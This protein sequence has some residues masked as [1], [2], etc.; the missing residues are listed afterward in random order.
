MPWRSSTRASSSTPKPFA[1][2]HRS[3]ATS[4][5]RRARP[6]A[7]STSSSSSIGRHGD[8]TGPRRIDARRRASIAPDNPFAGPAGRAGWRSGVRPSFV[9][10]SAVCRSTMCRATMCRATVRRST[11]CRSTVCRPAACRFAAHS[12][13]ACRF[14]AAP[15]PNP[16]RSTSVPTPMLNALSVSRPISRAR[17][18]TAARFAQ[19]GVQL[20]GVARL[21][22][23]RSESA[24]QF[25]I[26]AS[27]ARTAASRAA[28]IALAS[29]V[30]GA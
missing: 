28:A 11:V 21:S 13:S 26:C 12:L 10:R 5:S 2:P 22:R 18:S 25:D 7:T 14:A 4:A 16:H 3:K 29:A 17:T 15:G 19:I 1:I 6:R 30:G 24:F 9:C 23:D 8:G 27:T 20:P